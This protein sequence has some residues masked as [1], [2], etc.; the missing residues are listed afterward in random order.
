VEWE[1]DP[2]RVE[3][4]VAA[5]GLNEKSK[6]LSTLGVKMP[7]S[8]DVCPLST[9]ERELYRSN[10]MRLAYLALDRPELQFGSKE[11]AQSMQGP[12]K[13]DMEQKRA[14]RFLIGMP[15][16]VHRFAAQPMRQKVAAFSERSRRLPEDQ[17][18]YEL[19]NDLLRKTLDQEYV[20]NAGC[21]CIEREFY[22]AVKTA[23][24]GLGMIHMLRDMG[25]DI[26]TP[27]DEKFDA[28]AGIGIAS[29]RGAGR[30]SHIHT[31]TLWLQRA[32]NDG[33]A[34]ISKVPGD[35][36]PADLGTK[37]LDRTTIEMI[38]NQC[39]FVALKGRSGIA[40]RASLDSGSEKA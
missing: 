31:P 28:T 32:V 19:L 14:V 6:S 18:V 36:S 17:E 22:A 25:V 39:G 4:L 33:R 40:L 3:I 23:S 38:W 7:K 29:R 37:F 35:R 1:P 9:E 11:L 26:E 8:A 15:R 10:T 20:I 30:I 12:T 5:L 24:L 21:D 13:F 27:L 2:R 34:S 16:L